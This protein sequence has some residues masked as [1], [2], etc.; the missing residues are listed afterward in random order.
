VLVLAFQSLVGWNVF[1]LINNFYWRR[2]TEFVFDCSHG[3]FVCKGSIKLQT[4]FC[5]IVLN[6]FLW[7][8][9]YTGFGAKR[10]GFPRYKWNI[11]ESGVKHHQTIKR[12][13]EIIFKWLNVS[14]IN[15]TPR[16]ER[17][18]GRNDPGPIMAVSF[19][20]GGNRRTGR[21]PPT[22]RKSNI[23]KKYK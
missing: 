17:E 7:I 12:I 6:K 2:H 9:S 23:R 15:E 14:E 18:S 22:C 11:V 21:K 5:V 13:S 4:M 10:P 19:I 20:G 16:G 3:S 1:C 8:I